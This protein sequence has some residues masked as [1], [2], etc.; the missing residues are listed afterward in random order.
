M[1]TNE[2]RKAV[3]GILD[4]LKTEYTT[5]KD[6]Y[7]AEADSDAL[8]PHIVYSFDT[9]FPTGLDRRDVDMYIDLWDR[10][11]SYFL[12]EDVADSI[13]DIFKYRNFP[14]EYNLPTTYFE[15]RRT[16]D[17]SDKDIK[18]IQLIFTVQNYGR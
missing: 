9:A 16:V 8:Y 7:Y 4:T 12:L 1:K 14:Q 17:D 2:L 18:H 11:E 6:V 13:D 5:I 15:T 10:S 3:K